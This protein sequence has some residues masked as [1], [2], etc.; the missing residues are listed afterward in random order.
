MFLFVSGL[1]TLRREK[2]RRERVVETNAF[3]GGRGW[4]NLAAFL[5]RRRRHVGHLARLQILAVVVCPGSGDIVHVEGYRPGA[6][7]RREHRHE[8]E[9]HQ[10]IETQACE[11][12]VIES[13]FVVGGR[14]VR[15]RGIIADSCAARLVHEVFGFV[16]DEQDVARARAVVVAADVKGRD[17]ES[18]GWVVPMLA[19]T[20]HAEDLGVCWRLRLYRTSGIIT[21][22]HVEDS[23]VF[24]GAGAERN[25]RFRGIR[26]AFTPLHEVIS[27]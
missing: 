3:G 10:I 16:A 2:V 23:Q 4:V 1:T 15:Y 21:S 5:N 27:T 13:A 19:G 17:V 11:V 20:E 9:R 8:L 7:A 6:D 26:P 25:F 12:D 24:A 14:A 22:R 18:E